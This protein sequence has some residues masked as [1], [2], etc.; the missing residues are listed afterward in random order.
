MIKATVT[1]VVNVCLLMLF[2][3][4]YPERFVSYSVE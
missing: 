3:I 4:P 1:I 2:F